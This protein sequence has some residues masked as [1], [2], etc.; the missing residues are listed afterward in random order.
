MTTR[1]IA[2]L[3]LLF[4]LALAPG[5]AT[6]SEPP[7]EVRIVSPLPGTQVEGDVV[8]RWESQGGE[9][10]RRAT[11][12]LHA[13]AGV[14][15]VHEGA[16]EGHARV[17]LAG[18]PNGT[19]TL[20]V[21]LTDGA[22]TARARTSVQLGAPP[23]TQ[24]PRETASRDR[25]DFDGDGRVDERERERCAQ[26]AD[27]SSPDAAPGCRAELER[28]QAEREALRRDSQA[29]MER[30][31]EEQ[32]ARI[33]AFAEVERT[34]EEW[35]AF[36]EQLAA[37]RARLEESV[38]QQ[39][40]ALEAR[41]A[42]LS[43]CRE[44]A[45]AA[46]ETSCSASEAEHLRFRALVD[47]Q[48]RDFEAGYEARLARFAEQQEEARRAFFADERSEDEQRAFAARQHEERTRFHATMEDARL[49]HRRAL[50]HQ[51]HEFQARQ[52]RACLAPAAEE[53]QVT[54]IQRD[55]R[56]ELLA[57]DLRAQARIEEWYERHGRDM[58]AWSEETQR[59]FIQM[60]VEL[61]TAREACEARLHAQWSTDVR[62]RLAQARPEDRLGGFEASAE[63]GEA[64][65]RF[66]SFRYERAPAALHTFVVQGLLLVESLHAPATMAEPRL[67]GGAFEAEGE[68]RTQLRIQAHD[69]PTGALSVACRAGEAGAGSAE[70]C[71]LRLP[72]HA[73]VV[74]EPQADAARYVVELGEQRAMLHV[75]GPHAWDG[76]ALSLAGAFRLFLP[77]ENFALPDVAN[78]HREELR[79]AVDRG[80]LLGEVTVVRTSEGAR[81]EA[82]EYG[83]LGEEGEPER[84]RV[85]VQPPR[86]DGAVV[87]DF[88][89]DA[90]SGRTVAFNLDASL[91]DVRDLARA[92]FRVAYYEL[93]DEGEAREVPIRRAQ[94]LA[95]VLEPGDAPEWWVV[96]DAHGV[97]VLVSNPRFSDKRIEVHAAE[98][99]EPVERAPPPADE[100]DPPR[101]ERATPG[102]GLAWLLVALLLARR[103][104]RR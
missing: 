2:I 39:T 103:M 1:C 93:D 67:A 59:A 64:V 45:A 47:Q 86:D 71:V 52:A 82:V 4:G 89:S 94:S 74:G 83:G 85:R 40:D 31:H 58:A 55:A 18:L 77:A 6:A 104:R 42:S 96:L 102:P 35:T 101:D 53:R 87:I 28:L 95:A 84:L 19:Y 46:P 79:G 36:R 34:D 27:A 26:L 60:R 54:D 97:Q 17:A 48:A 70:A 80:R 99:A 44:R 16:D 62:E 24:E 72:A 90:R 51:W 98:A 7:L 41:A 65:G 50:E 49:S 23:Q 8:L 20:V 33:R 22:S 9:G 78:R 21:V 10:A 56:G 73:R 100:P 30:F 14:R 91:F 13:P 37:E 76:V 11:V 66:V 3:A 75:H 15:T 12:E 32:N 81:A 63:A 68:G 88:G 69:N 92:R 61:Q 57:C 5:L 38:R 25:C 29:R 43:D